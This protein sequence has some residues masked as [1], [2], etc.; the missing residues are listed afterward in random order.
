M[1]KCIY[2]KQKIEKAKKSTQPTNINKIGR[3]N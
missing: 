2:I 3:A 1:N